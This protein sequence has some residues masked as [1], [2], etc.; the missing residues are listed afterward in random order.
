MNFNEHAGKPLLRAAGIDTPP[1]EV[2]ESVQAARAA[3][4][5]IGA[6]VVK[7]QVPTGKRGKAGGIAVCATVE[8]AEAAA[9]RILG[10]TIGE[11]EVET[12]LIEGQVPIAREFYA[13][14]LN[15]PESKGPLMLFSPEGGMDIEEIAEEHPDKLARIPIDIAQGCDL[16]EITSELA[17]MGLGNAPALA[18]ILSKLYDAYRANDA[19][20]MEINPLVQTDDGSLI[21][22][23][24]K[25]TL[26]DSAIKR[27]EELA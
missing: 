10:M 25:F 19:E 3:A 13:A 22:L 4:E 8:D 21:A 26:D 2:V 12:L 11:H 1:G 9:A 16:T 18:L 27:R 17:K 24:C 6:C 15:D 7:A 5:K 14:V 20:L 23:D